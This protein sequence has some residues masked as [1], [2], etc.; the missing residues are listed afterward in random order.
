MESLLKDALKR[1]QACRC[2][3]DL[4]AGNAEMMSYPDQSFDMVF[5]HQSF[6]HIV[7]HEKAMQEFYRGLKPGGV[8]L[9]GESCGCKNGSRS[10]FIN[11]ELN[12]RDRTLTEM[13]CFCVRILTTYFI[14]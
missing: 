10:G 12:D 3:V 11:R 13:L 1:A 4:I 7:Q 2:K 14:E 5:C 8:L 6:H 9:F